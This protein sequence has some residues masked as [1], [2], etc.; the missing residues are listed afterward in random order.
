MDYEAGASGAS[1][2]PLVVARDWVDGNLAQPSQVTLAHIT[3][4]DGAVGDDVAVLRE[5]RT[6]ALL[7]LMLAEGDSLL[8]TS[9]VVCP[10]D[11][12]GH[13]GS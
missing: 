7:D 4:D 12:A 8:V 6:V 11:L 13:S 10:T 1:D 2:D 3:A 9:Y 5:G